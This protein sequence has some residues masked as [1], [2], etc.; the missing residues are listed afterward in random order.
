MSETSDGSSAPQSSSFD[1]DDTDEPEVTVAVV[2]YPNE[3]RSTANHTIDLRGI[4]RLHQGA[5]RDH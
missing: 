2:K 5:F 3:N 4:H 1:D